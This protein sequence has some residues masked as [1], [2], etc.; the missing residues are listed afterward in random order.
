VT[1]I[2]QLEELGKE[3]IARLK[4]AGIHSVE[5][6]LERTATPRGRKELAALTGISRDIL[7]K[8]VKHLDLSRIEGLSPRV[9]SLLDAAGVSNI[10]KLSRQ[11]PQEFIG[12]LQEINDRKSIVDEL[13]SAEE[14]TRWIHQAEAYAGSPDLSP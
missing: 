14:V 1:E 8:W 6:L 12:K 4:A 9:L 5:R 7:Q 13:P 2:S 10:V 11:E 3:N